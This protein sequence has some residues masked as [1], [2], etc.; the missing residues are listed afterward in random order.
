L[1][2]KAKRLEEKLLPADIDF[3]RVI[4]DNICRKR[5]DDEAEI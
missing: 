3:V 5:R 2:E 4:V 1:I